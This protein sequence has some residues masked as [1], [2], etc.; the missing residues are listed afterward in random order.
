MP[1]PISV[2]TAALVLVGFSS[3]EP[4]GAQASQPS[5]GLQSTEFSAQSRPPRARTRIRVTPAYPYRVLST[6][7]P[8]P[9]TYEYPGPG[10]VRQCSSWLAS[11]NRLSGTVITPQ[12]R[13]WWQR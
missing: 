11:E 1:Q 12:M 13:C 6:P 9:Y 2:I 8:V 3:L 5:A 4:L 7:Y 10:A